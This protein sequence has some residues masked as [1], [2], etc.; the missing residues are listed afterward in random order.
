MVNHLEI[1]V[2]ILIHATENKEKILD[3]VSE[4][5]EI[6]KG[7]FIEERL[8]GHFGNPILL[9]KA[10]LVKKRA[11]TLIQRIISKISKTQM[12]EFLQEIETRIED[13]ALFLR[14]SKQDIVSKI[15]NFK[16]DDAIKI[17]ISQPIYKK[18][19]LV[20]TYTELLSAK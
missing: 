15:I 10:K 5:L 3:S 12:D 2:E 20:R 17:R 18:S 14:I 9:L 1:I 16:E 13:S 7:E 8:A 11:E 6:T 4:T 19:E